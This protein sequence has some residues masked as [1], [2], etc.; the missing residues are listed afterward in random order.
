[1]RRGATTLVMLAA[2]WLLPLLLTGCDGDGDNSRA[3]VL[4]ECRL[5]DAGC[6]LQ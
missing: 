6:R 2:L 5:D 1:M 4:E 3:F